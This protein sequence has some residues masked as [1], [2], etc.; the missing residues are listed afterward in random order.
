MSL[1]LNLS[2]S[3]YP[4]V[5]CKYFNYNVPKVHE[6][7]LLRYLLTSV[8]K[9]PSTLQESIMS[10]ISVSVLLGIHSRIGTVVIR[11]M[12]AGSVTRIAHC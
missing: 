12:E 4:F 11:M 9:I 7:F 3:L 10:G 1:K 2:L 8:S 6:K 5:T